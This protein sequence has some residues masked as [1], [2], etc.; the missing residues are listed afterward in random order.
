MKKIYS[1]TVHI[2]L[3]LISLSLAGCFSPLSTLDSGVSDSPGKGVLRILMQDDPSLS[4]N[5]LSGS[6]S[7]RALLPPSLLSEDR[8]IIDVVIYREEEP[9]FEKLGHPVAEI[10]DIA[11]L[12]VGVE[13]VVQIRVKTKADDLVASGSAPCVISASG[14]SVT[15]PLRRS[16]DGFGTLN[17]SYDLSSLPGIE[18]AAVTVY[19]LAAEVP[20]VVNVP[21]GSVS[22]VDGI[23]S[24]AWSGM[25][26]GRY[27]LVPSVLFDG[28]SQ[29]VPVGDDL[30]AVVCD[31]ALTGDKVITCD[32]SSMKKAALCWYVSDAPAAGNTGRRPDSPVSFAAAFSAAMDSPL[33][34][35]DFPAEIA[36]TSSCD[37]DAVESF[38]VTKPLVL[39]RIASLGFE[40]SVRNINTG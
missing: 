8:S 24:L 1:F 23:C 30:Y 18:T 27:L 32:L 12:T 40:L 11:G 10:L 2:A 7:S 31:G 14:S 21:A 36:F 5:Q 22:Y 28:R 20:S 6:S 4:E 25:P 37:V 19:S 29:N 38:A 17:V 39:R 15:I 3:A 9:V 26:S 35:P 34:S 13:H 16:F 33:V